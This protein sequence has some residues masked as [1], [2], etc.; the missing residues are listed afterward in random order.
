M[1]SVYRS[2]YLAG[3]IADLTYD[4]ATAWRRAAASAFKENGIEAL[5]PMRAKEYLRK[6]GRM[7]PGAQTYPAELGI[8][9]TPCGISARDSFDVKRCDVML[10]NF[11]GADRISIGTVLE[12]GMAHGYD[13]TKPIV[14]A[15]DP[16]NVHNHPMLNTY[17]QFILPSLE[18][19][20]DVV[21]AI[22]L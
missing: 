20:I 12:I 17:S 3:P 11:I 18:D 13:A 22:L 5:D 2:V 21:K 9:S 8:L 16:D 1:R 10:V 15:M 19:A 6:V 7:L 14:V 4:T